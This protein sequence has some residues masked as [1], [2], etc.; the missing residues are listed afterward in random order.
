MGALANASALM[1]SDEF[2]GLVMA[3]AVYTATTVLAEPSSTENYTSRRALAIEVLV[4]P[5]IIT[6]RLVSILSGTPSIALTSSD[7][8]QISDDLII[9]R[10]A[11][12]WTALAEI[13]FPPPPLPPSA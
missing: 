11:E 2:R 6:D 9:T 7:P 1:K 13:L 12:V 8:S 5:Q 4:N 3:A 10:A